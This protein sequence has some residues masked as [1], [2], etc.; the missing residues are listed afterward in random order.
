MPQY[1]CPYCSPSYQIHQQDSHGE[2]RCG[3]CGEPL[4]KIPVFRTTQALALLTAIAFVSPLVIMVLSFID[5]QKST[6]PKKELTTILTTKH[7]LMQVTPGNPYTILN[8][9]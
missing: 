3:N 6:I 9:T 4:L 1:Y 8:K 5:N 7:L 2:M